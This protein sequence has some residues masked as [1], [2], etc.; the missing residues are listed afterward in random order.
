MFKVF[1]IRQ[2]IT[3]AI[4]GG[5]IIYTLIGFLVVNWLSVRPY[6]RVFIPKKYRRNGSV[7]SMP[8][9]LR[10]VIEK[11]GTT[12]VKF[13]Q[14]LADRPDIVSEK[15]RTELKKLQSMARPIDH[16]LAMRLIEE[17]LG[18]PLNKYFNEIENKKCIGAASIGQV[19]KG[20]LKN[21]EEVVIKIQRP[22]IESKIA[23][24]LELLKYLARQLVK[25]YPGF[26][27]VDIVGFVEEFGE[28]LKRE[29]DYVNEASNVNRFNQMFKDVPYCKIPKVY[30]N[31]STPRLL[32][33]EYISG[34]NP[35]DTRQLEQEG[36][37]P[38]EIATNGVN[39]ILTM[40]FKHG[41]FHADPHP[42][43]L[44]ILP[45]NK[46]ALIDFGM[47][48]SLKPAHMQF[49]ADF[50]L[51]L[52]NND[53]AVITDALLVLCNKKFFADKDDLEFYVHDMLTRNSS[54]SYERI[55]FSQILNESIKLIVKYELRIPATIYLLLKA[56]ATIENFGSKL[57][58]DISLPAII[59]PY[60]KELVMQKFSPSVIVH[61]IVDTAKD[62]VSLIKDFP[63][64]MNEIL[65]KLKHGKLIHEIHIGGP[66]GWQGAVH[67]I[68]K[69]LSAALLL[70]FMLLVSAIMSI[71]GKTPWVGNVVFAISFFIALWLVLRSFIR[72]GI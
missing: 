24:D 65:F 44:F 32:V 49:L 69:A 36:Y 59:K 30:M 22:D 37:D 72:S 29:M 67:G 21:G 6:M 45:G 39:V 20:K 4:R 54:L 31:L 16:N 55:N 68:G 7:L 38:H 62:Y 47:V 66:E 13:G 51:G 23:L 60:A 18:G 25:E 43:N 34:I 53:A 48:G 15:L 27:T 58:P 1:R 33:M 3:R 5:H 64:E 28:T 40:I 63:A 17:E 57:Y 50:T 12:F 11:L 52:A 71:W 26:S 56:L 61:D 2:Y 70:G 19:Y 46:I 8:E 35:D 10:I 42:G 9:R 41:F 14:I